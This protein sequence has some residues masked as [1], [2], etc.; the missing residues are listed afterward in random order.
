MLVFPFLIFAYAV[1]GGSLIK[2]GRTH[3]DQALGLLVRTQPVGANQWWTA[4]VV[5]ALAWAMFIGD[6][7]MKLAAEL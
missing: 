3:W 2:N 7:W 1:A 4:L 6:G 5:L